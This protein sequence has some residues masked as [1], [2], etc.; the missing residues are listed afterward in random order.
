MVRKVVECMQVKGVVAVGFASVQTEEF[1]R[2][3]KVAVEADV[4]VVRLIVIRVRL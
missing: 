2:F 4:E 3:H 1:T